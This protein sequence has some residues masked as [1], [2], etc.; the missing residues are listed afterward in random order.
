M[1]RIDPAVRPLWRSPDCLQLGEDPVLAVLEPVPPGA[2]AVLG[3]LMDGVDA[4]GLDTTAARAGL[5]PAALRALLDAV[6]PALLPPA[7]PL[8]PAL[9]IA[10]DA[11]PDLAALLTLLLDLD[12]VRR[13]DA[14]VV[15]VAA[16]H[17]VAPAATV[18]YLGDDRPHLAVVF[19]DQAATVGPFV[20]PG[21]TP[22][23]RCAEEHRLDTPGRRAVAAQLLRRSGSRTTGTVL[24]RLRAGLLIA[25]ALTDL[26]EG[27]ETSLEGW[28]VRL[29][30]DGTVSRR[31]RPWHARCSCRAAEHPPA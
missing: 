17:L 4:L 14:D 21:R 12:P 19:G 28:A 9:R 3:A 31:P 5:A 13:E 8:L 18:R 10:V 11:P 2:D 23:L 29:T 20:R 26:R 15:V 24:T 7:A 30:P 25:T 22:C 1:L 27:R 16:H 6:G